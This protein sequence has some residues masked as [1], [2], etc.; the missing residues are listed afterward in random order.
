[1]KGLIWIC[2]IFLNVSFLCAGQ[3]LRISEKDFQ[4]LTNGITM[5]QA[6]SIL[7]ANARHQFTAHVKGQ[8]VQCVSYAFGKPFLYYYFLFTERRLSKICAPPLFDV[9]I[10]KRGEMKIE[11]REPVDPL[12]RIDAV[13]EAQDLSG[14]GVYQDLHKRLRKRGSG[15]A[16]MLPAFVILAPIWVP[17]ML[18]H[19]PG[20]RKEYRE[21][22]AWAAKF[23]PLKIALGQPLNVAHEVFG[24]PQSRYA[25]RSGFMNC[26]NGSTLKK[27]KREDHYS[28][29]CVIDDL[30]IITA[31][32]SNDFVIS[33]HEAAA[34]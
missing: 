13:L 3:D 33:V 16:S 26:W 8:H 7:G 29:V 2:T 20:T 30:G 21:N 5:A 23:D 34:N 32:F 19:A 31:I 12:K 28:P 15:D 1:M 6:Q 25:F 9:R 18:I 11:I 4:R 27:I 24:K 17:S 10:E 22:Q 14:L